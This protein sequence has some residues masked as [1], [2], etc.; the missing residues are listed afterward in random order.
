MQS[1]APATAAPAP[2]AAPPGGASHAKGVSEVRELSR[3]QSLI[4]RR[5]A[6]A[7]ATIPEFTLSCEIDMEAAVQMRASLKRLGERSERPGECTAH[8]LRGIDPVGARLRREI[9]RVL[10]K[11]DQPRAPGRRGALAVDRGGVA[12]QAPD[13]DGGGRVAVGEQDQH[14]V[15]GVHV[16]QVVEDEQVGLLGHRG[17]ERHDILGLE[18]ALVRA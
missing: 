16:V 7:K 3:T 6:E 10:G 9:A 2:A 13:H 14:P 1:T 11:D 4:A 5:M 15:V 17:Q 18:L 8:R 12:V